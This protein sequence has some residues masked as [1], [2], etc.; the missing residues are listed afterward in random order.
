MLDTVLPSLLPLAIMW[1]LRPQEGFSGPEIFLE[2]FLADVDG[3][4]V[5]Y[6]EHVVIRNRGFRGVVWAIPETIHGPKINQYP[7]QNKSIHENKHF[8]SPESLEIILGRLTEIG[9]SIRRHNFGWLPGCRELKRRRIFDQPA[10]FFLHIG[11][12]SAYLKA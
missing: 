8:C 6:F 10:R 3:C 11:P 1:L 7:N 5:E 4:L 9:F 2:V 12:A